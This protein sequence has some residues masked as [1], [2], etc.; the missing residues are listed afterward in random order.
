MYFF[1]AI[2]VGRITLTF[3][4]EY[5]FLISFIEV[6]SESVPSLSPHTSDI[7]EENTFIS[8]A[9]SDIVTG[10]LMK[11]IPCSNVW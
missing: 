2:P 10:C 7:T 5:Y 9:L 1:P 11:L 3:S 6:I 4:P 8:A